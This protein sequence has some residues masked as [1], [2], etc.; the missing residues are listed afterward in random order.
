MKGLIK[1]DF[2]VF[3]RTV[4]LALPINYVLSAL[5]II[6]SETDELLYTFPC[7]YSGMI[8]GFIPATLYSEDKRSGWNKY[9][10]VMPYR[11]RDYVIVKYLFGLVASL[12]YILFISCVILIKVNFSDWLDFDDYLFMLCIIVVCCL[13]PVAIIMPIALKH[14]PQVGFLAFGI[15]CLLIGFLCGMASGYLDALFEENV[16]YWYNG[17]RGS[18]IILGSVALISVI[19]YIISWFCSIKIYE[20]ADL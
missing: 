12:I 6:F 9:N 17:G 18:F 1:N 20:K 14:S 3:K 8:L 2:F 10:A 11:R 7:I 5:I 16:D 15:S 19:L 13:A 4:A